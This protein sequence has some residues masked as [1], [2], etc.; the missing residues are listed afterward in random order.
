MN[1]KRIFIK[2]KW[3]FIL[4]LLLVL[5]EGTILIL[6]PLF[7]GNAIDD[8]INNNLHGI[9]QLGVLG[10]TLLIVGVGRRV[11]DSRFYAKVYRQV[12]VSTL[13][14]IKDK[15]TSVKTARLHMIEELIEFL[16]N[17]LPELIN[18]IIGL[19]GVIG[20]LFAL[21]QKVFYGSLIV[22]GIIMLIYWVSSNKTVLYN[23]CANDEWERQ[24][25]IVS[26]P[27]S[28]KLGL[29]L[30]EMMR[31]NIKLSDLEALNFSLSWLVA[32]SFL[33]ASILI[34]IGDGIVTYGSLLAL[35]IYVFQYIENVLNLP[36]FY[37]NCLRLNEIILRL[38][39][40]DM[41]HGPN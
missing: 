30:K 2:H 28:I 8:V 13:I 15:N 24:V 27:S 25:E 32:L 10:L 12:G 9:I 17:S 34:S 7:I 6:F 11:F 26:Q 40:D 1:L 5:F 35:V 29:H 23:K 4:T 19:F 33:I 37:Q 14:R 3:R 16:E 36:L 39:H 18:T 20:I 22:T 31:W 21:N 38:K 41:P